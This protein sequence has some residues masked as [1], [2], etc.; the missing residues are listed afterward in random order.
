MIQQGSLPFLHLVHLLEQIGVLGD[1]PAVDEVVLV[2]RTGS[3]LVVAQG[4]PLSP[5]TGNEAEVAVL[6]SVAVEHEAQHPGLVHPQ[7]Q[8]DQIQHEPRVLAEV[9]RLIEGEVGG[10]P[11]P[12]GIFGMKAPGDGAG[13]GLLLPLPIGLVPVEAGDPLLQL[14][15]TLEVLRQGLAVLSAQTPLQSLGLIQH[16]VQN[17]PVPLQP[18]LVAEEGVEGHGRIDLLGQ[19]LVGASPGDGGIVEPAAVSG[20]G[21]AQRQRR[22]LGMVTDPVGDLLIDGGPGTAVVASARLAREQG[23]HLSGVSP[24]LLQVGMGQV[25]QDVDLVLDWPEGFQARLEGES[26]ALAGGA[27]LMSVDAQRKESRHQS[28]G[29]PGRHI[30]YRRGH[31]AG[32]RLQ[33]RQGHAHP[34]NSQE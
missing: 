8:H 28:N 12:S 3:F 19:G 32:N 31:H 24:Q 20:G 1:V 6:G 9:P 27:P 14:A 4:V 22:E 21:D 13:F 15:N 26:R 11:R 7:R 29:G 10:L 25:L 30:S 17:A 5:Y 34:G 33:P 18:R 2:Q 16:Q 23:G